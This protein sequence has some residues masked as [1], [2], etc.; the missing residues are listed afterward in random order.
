MSQTKIRPLGYL[1]RDEAFCPGCLAFSYGGHGLA[2]RCDFDA[3]QV[4]DTI[5]ARLD[6]DR[7]ANRDCNLFPVEITEDGAH[8]CG[9]C[10]AFLSHS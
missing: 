9:G 1:Y 3:E 8:D 7:A 5:A 10:G 2:I 4:L 6:I